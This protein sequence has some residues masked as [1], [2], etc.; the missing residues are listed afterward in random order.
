VIREY[1]LTDMTVLSDGQKAARK[2]VNEG[3]GLFQVEW[4]FS[5]GGRQYNKGEVIQVGSY[6]V[7]PKTTK[8]SD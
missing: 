8:K 4:N 7:I 3:D 5:L 2:Q 1:K 6:E